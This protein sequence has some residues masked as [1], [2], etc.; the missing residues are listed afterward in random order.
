MYLSNSLA[1]IVSLTLFG[2]VSSFKPALSRFITLF[3]NYLKTVDK[4][5][6]VY[7]LPINVH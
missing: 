3:L 1:I 4:L 5:N 7:I 6:Y 2:I